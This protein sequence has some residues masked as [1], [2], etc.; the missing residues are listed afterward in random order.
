MT[1]DRSL[2]IKILHLEFQKVTKPD[3]TRLGEILMTKNPET[4]DIND[5]GK[6]TLDGKSKVDISSDSIPFTSSNQ[7]KKPEVAPPKDAGATADDVGMPNSPAEAQN[8]PSPEVVVAKPKMYWKGYKEFIHTLFKSTVSSMAKNMSYKFGQPDIIKIEH[9][10]IYHSHDRRGR[11]NDYTVKTGGHF[12]EV[13]WKDKDG[14]DYLDDDDYY[15]PKLGIAL[16]EKKIRKKSGKVITLIEQV[17]YWNDDT[18]EN[19]K[20][21]HTHDLI[22]LGS[23]QLSDAK[24]KARQA[25]NSA[26]ISG[27]VQKSTPA[28]APTAPPDVEAAE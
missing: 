17:R 27:M 22:N 15:S 5:S 18:D 7:T 26:A 12:H 21:H 24:I 25:A 10:H 14:K 9:V 2:Q 13:F 3:S 19:I 1:I 16:W 6:A 8:M 4:L 28:P 11:K 20:D 23:E